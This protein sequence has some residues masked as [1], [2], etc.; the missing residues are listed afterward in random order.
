MYFYLLP[1]AT[2]VIGFCVG[3]SL[4]KMNC[5]CFTKPKRVHLRECIEENQVQTNQV[6]E[7]Q[8]QNRTPGVFVQFVSSQGWTIDIL[9]DEKRINEFYDL[10]SGQ[11]LG[12]WYRQLK[13]H[14][15]FIHPS[16]LYVIRLMTEQ[17]NV[18]LPV[19]TDEQITSFFK[20]CK[21]RLIHERFRCFAGRAGEA[22]VG[23]G[24][25]AASVTKEDDE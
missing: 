3:Y 4:S 2:Y 19:A 25:T 12:S 21:N 8:V 15:S 13:Q 1:F 5:S 22:A 18:T 24:S 17:T 7:K 23:S 14:D 6:R 9:I 10:V 11:F 20:S 16:G